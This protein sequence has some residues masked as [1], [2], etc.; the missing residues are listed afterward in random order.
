MSRYFEEIDV[1]ALYRNGATSFRLD[2]QT[3]NLLS[4]KVDHADWIMP[5]IPEDAEI[6]DFLPEK[7]LAVLSAADKEEIKTAL[8]TVLADPALFKPFRHF[9]EMTTH[10]VELFNGAIDTDWHHDGL[11]GKRGHAGEFFLLCYIGR[12]EQMIWQDDWGGAFDYG[13]RTLGDN[14][15]HDISAPEEFQSIRPQHRNCV[16]G[17]NANPRLVHRSA[18]LKAAVNRY[19]V[20]ASIRLKGSTPFG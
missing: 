3:A 4:Q 2:V 19:V 12:G 14:W 7:P 5:D 6:S 10:S 17:W 8:N 1:N 13:E 18:P 16:L 20:A 11:A 9:G 15:V